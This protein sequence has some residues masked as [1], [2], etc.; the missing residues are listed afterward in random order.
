[1]KFLQIQGKILHQQKDQDLIYC[2]GLE[3]TLQYLQD[4]VM[5]DLGAPG[6]PTLHCKEGFH[7][8]NTQDVRL[9]LGDLGPECLS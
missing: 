3:L 9:Y 6:S 4:V 8:S 5:Y 7:A 1:M 2:S